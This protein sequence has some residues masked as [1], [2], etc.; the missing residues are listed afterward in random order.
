MNK[1]IISTVLLISFLYLVSSQKSFV[2]P[3]IKDKN[4]PDPG[5]IYYEGWYYVTNTGG[6]EKA[7]FPIHKSK[8]LQNWQF[9]GYAFVEGKLPV[10]AKPNDA[11]WAPELHIIQGK[12][13]LYFTARQ[14]VTNLLC[15]GV[16]TADSIAGPYKDKGV[17]LIMNTTVGSIDATVM[18]ISNDEYYLIWKDDGNGKSPKIHTW[19]WAQKLTNDGLKVTGDK[20]ALIRETLPWEGDLVEAP[21]V[22]KRGDWYYLFYS[23]YGY[24]NPTYAVGVARSKNPLGPYQ[25]KGDPILKTG[26]TWVGPGHCSV[27]LDHKVKDQYVMIYHSW[28][29]KEVCGKYHRLLLVDYVKWSADGWPY[30]A[31]QSSEAILI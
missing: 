24:C 13:R 18:T 29:G 27:L 6:S 7:K 12:F 30:M 20:T 11:F 25:K 5:A 31:N 10:W 3:V 21:W 23:G 15:I 19:L 1:S 4:L 14:L 22:I 8:D 9:V 2:N 17:P 26:P 16:A 28:H